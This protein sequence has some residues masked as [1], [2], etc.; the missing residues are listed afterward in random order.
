[1][2][3]GPRVPRLAPE[4][5]DGFTIAEAIVSMFVFAVVAAV[6]TGLLV[7]V[8]GV[9]KTNTQRV[10]AASLAN[11]GIEVARGSDLST[12][13]DG[14][15]VSTN[16]TVDGVT[17]QVTQ[18][19]SEVTSA[20]G[21]S[22]CD[23]GNGGSAAFK[24]I[25]DIVTW[26]R[27]GDIKPV[28]VDTLRNLGVTQGVAAVS[29][30]DNGGNPV[31][32]IT[33]AMA[34]G[35][36]TQT[37]G[38]DGCAVFSGLTPYSTYTASVNQAGY[39]GV[40]G[41]ALV[42]SSGI[43][44]NPSTVTRTTISYA[45]PGTLQVAYS[46][47]ANSVAPANVP[48]SFNSSGFQP[49]STVA[50]PYCS[51][52]SAVACITAGTNSVSAATLFPGVYS[53]WAGTCAD[54]RPLL[55]APGGTVVSN[56]V[57]VSARPAQLGAV[58][59]TGSKAIRSITATHAADGS[60]ASGEI[61]TLSSVAGKALATPAGTWTIS[62]TYTASS[63]AAASFTPVLSIVTAGSTSSVPVLTP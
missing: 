16:K 2:N 57:V 25:T 28:R 37:T 33:V 29:V 49:N 41:V 53:A 6:A 55:N 3:I 50:L 60:C 23:S 8:V 35:G 61:Y 62:G 56:S 20:N 36:Q 42:S 31:A 40:N 15:S 30:L 45:Q 46:V 5:Q 22:A 9:G 17:Y 34:P 4:G 19:V 11:Q 47:P 48:F 14:T 26:P 32:G 43:G 63:G 27:M 38:S 10:T 51:V 1:M 13:V 39:V 24:L 7:Q 21:T 44:I 59:V 12:L 52:N 18:T 58:N 54:A